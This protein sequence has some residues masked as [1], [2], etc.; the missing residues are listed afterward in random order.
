[1]AVR[2]LRSSWWVD[3]SFN[4]ARYRRR[5]P[6]NTKSGAL[7]F[8]ATLRSRLA[9]GEPLD[10]PLPHDADEQTFEEFCVKWFEDYVTPTNRYSEQRAKAYILHASLIPFFGK[11]PIARVTTLQIER[12]KAAEIRAGT[13]SKTLKNRLAVLNKCLVNAYDWLEL[14]GKRPIITWPRPAPPRTHYLSGEECEKLLSHADGTLREMILMS[15]RTGMRQGELKGLQWTSIDWDTGGVVIRHSL[16]D[17]GKALEAPK[18]NRERYIPLDAALRDALYRRRKS[19][20]YVF[21][22]ASGQPFNE[23]RLNRWLTSACK[24]AGLRRITWH[25][26]RHTFASQLAM[27]GV[28][29]HIVQTLLGHTNVTTTMR[30]AHVAPSALRPAIE[31]LSAPRKHPLGQPAGNEWVDVDLE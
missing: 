21:V 4:R 29:L 27:K 12:Y 3:I 25:V 6:I 30:Y 5:S 8:E 19:A 17:H 26:L 1:M 18:G 2:R 31:M 16:R 14:P 11:T 22:D 24:K 7:E 13:S 20:G 9:H 23:P 15:L 10:G 28:P